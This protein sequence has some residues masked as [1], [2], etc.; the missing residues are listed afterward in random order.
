MWQVSEMKA[1]HRE[2][3]VVSIFIVIFAAIFMVVIT[4]SFLLVMMR[5]QQQATQYNLSQN[6]Y[7][8]AM[9]GVSDAERAIALCGANPG[10]AGCGQLDSGSC[11]TLNN[12]A[13]L[14]VGFSKVDGNEEYQ[15]Q[16]AA[17][18]SNKLNLAYTCVM[19]NTQPDNYQANILEGVPL[20]IPLQANGQ[21]T[22]LNFSWQREIPQA[23]PSYPTTT[24]L[25]DHASWND[26]TH[27]YP[28]VMQLELIRIGS[29]GSVKLSDLDK[30]AP[31]DNQSAETLMLYPIKDLVAGNPSP[32]TLVDFATDVRQQP[33]ALRPVNCYDD[34]STNGNQ[35][36]AR[37]IDRGK[38]MVSTN[39]TQSLFLVMTPIY[40]N[41][42]VTLSP[43]GGS[44]LTN[45]QASVDSTGRAN[46]LFRRVQARVDTIP[47][48]ATYPNAAVSLQGPLCK[49]FTVLPNSYTNNGGQACVWN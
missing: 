4:V 23:T 35:C 22:A 11:Q 38:Q 1:Q 17:D 29:N 26:A 13:G 24:G 5:D 48:P 18:G 34:P 21:A 39:G 12:I 37:L 45:I 14:G 20:V 33:S 6:A 15:I 41:A 16:T 40:G 47:H 3:G 36:Y 28:P 44:Y 32:S 42:A 30:Q 31:G 49:N 7:D 25:L 2:R 43:S 9:S 8:S 10:N 46:D 19:I 27:N